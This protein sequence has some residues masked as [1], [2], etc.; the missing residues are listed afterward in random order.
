MLKKLPKEY[1]PVFG[2]INSEIRDYARAHGDFL[3]T[4]AEAVE[5]VT[6]NGER[7]PANEDVKD[8]PSADTIRRFCRK[9]GTELPEDGICPN[10]GT[11]YV[12][13]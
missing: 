5:I 2:S 3:P 9:C 6:N 13:N 7:L 10:C 11:H 12:E 1:A 8:E 4:P